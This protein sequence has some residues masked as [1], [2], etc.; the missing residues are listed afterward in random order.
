MSKT[1]PRRLDFIVDKLSNSIEHVLTGKVF[2]TRLIRLYPSDL[3]LLASLKW[4]FDWTLEL[5]TPSH[6]VY[7]LTTMDDPDVIHGLI[8]ISDEQDHIFMDLLESA[9][10][11]VGKKKQFDGVAGN[12]V[13]FACYCAFKKGYDGII[14]FEAKTI[15]IGHYEKMLGAKRI[16]GNRMFIDTK[17]AEGLVLNY[18]KN[19][20]EDRLQEIR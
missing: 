17:E 8:T 3:A 9:P 5:Q 20:D 18:L 2:A 14:V 10:F 19:F 7:A 15:L 11:N 12:L 16:A 13:A 6:E 4:Q 1:K